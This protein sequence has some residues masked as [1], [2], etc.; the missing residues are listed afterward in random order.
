MDESERM[1]A[2]SFLRGSLIGQDIIGENN[3]EGGVTSSVRE[4]TSSGKDSNSPSEFQEI[5]SSSLQ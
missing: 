4:N 3:N 1:P 2:S 5:S